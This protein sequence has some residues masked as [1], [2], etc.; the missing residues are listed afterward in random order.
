VNLRG[1]VLPLVEARPLLG[2]PVRAGSGRAR[3]LVLAD[4]A[5]R[6]AIV[7]E[8]VLGLAAFDDVQP[9]P[10]AVPGGLTLGE[11][12]DEAGERATVID[13]AALLTAVRRAWNFPS[14][15]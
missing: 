5:R 13:A 10:D 11:L 4:G 8:R 3:A 12:V 1:T 14:G 6:A 2:L 7:I 9:G 15:G